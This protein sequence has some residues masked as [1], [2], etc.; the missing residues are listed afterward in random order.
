[1][2]INAGP[3]YVNAEKDYLNAKSLEDKLYFLEEMIRAAP[4]HKSSENLLSALKRRLKRLKESVEKGRKKSEGRKGIRKE[5]FQFVMVGKTNRGRSSLLKRL[6]NAQ[7]R[8]GE[9]EY[10]TRVTEIGTFYF[11]GVKAQIV[12]VPSI[13]S[14]YFDVGI[15]NNADCLLIVVEKLEELGELEEVFKRN[16]GKRIVVVNKVDLLSESEERK[17]RARMKSKR[18]EGVI[19]SALTGEGI[20]ELKK[21]MLSATGMIRIFLKEPGKKEN[22]ERPLVLNEGATIRD[23]A[24]NILKGYSRN[25]KETRITGPSAKFV[26][27]RV[28]LQH[29]VKDRDVVEFRAR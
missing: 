12:D 14:E 29:E 19:V 4:K 8:T 6:S 9:Y 16:M 11:E 23:V 25:V 27:Q 3:E 26:N 18:I 2:P 20:N 10:T 7:P 28:G 24:E 1:M 5:G 21:R 22:R 17:L 13:G 15:V